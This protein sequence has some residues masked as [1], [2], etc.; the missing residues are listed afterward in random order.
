MSMVT[1]GRPA[2]GEEKMD[3]LNVARN[4]DPFIAAPWAH[5][6]GPIVG[7][8]AKATALLRCRK[9]TQCAGS[10]IAR[11]QSVR[12]PRLTQDQRLPAWPQRRARRL[13]AGAVDTY[14]SEGQARSADR[15]HIAGDL[16]NRRPAFWHNIDPATPVRTASSIS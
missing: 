6:F 11:R 1:C 12:Q 9:M 10:E 16:R 15:R 14:T 7:F 8:A 2:Q 5:K 3:S 13:Q 4:G